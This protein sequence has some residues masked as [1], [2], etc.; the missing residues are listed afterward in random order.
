VLRNQVGRSWIGKAAAYTLASVVAG[1]AAGTA[2]GAAG[3]LL[4]LDIR[5]AVGRILAISAVAVGSLE[6]FGRRIQSL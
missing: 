2:L 4:P 1:L 6:L 3:G 5:L